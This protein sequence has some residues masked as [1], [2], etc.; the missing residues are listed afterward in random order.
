M[1]APA[2]ILNSDA[3]ALY[4]SAFTQEML[5]YVQSR[6]QTLV[7]MAS[8]NT[9]RIEDPYLLEEVAQAAIGADAGASFQVLYQT[10][11]GGGIGTG[12]VVSNLNTF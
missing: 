8:R 5:S 4:V 1:E 10:V 6:L 3:V 9:R 11:G 7:T 12:A 2:I